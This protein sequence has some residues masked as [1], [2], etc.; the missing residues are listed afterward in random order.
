MNTWDIIRP[1]LLGIRRRR[2]R[3][4]LISF[5][6]AVCV[7]GPL[8]FYLSKEPPRFQTSATL[9]V[10]ARPDRIPLFQEFSP[11]RPLAVQLAIL[12]SRN[13][14]EAVLESLPRT[15]RQDLLLNTYYVDYTRLF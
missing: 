10:E 8:A 5:L 4:V 14:A 13:M 1:I 9:L 3:L 7:F 11:S 12:R 6:V 2:K 15:S